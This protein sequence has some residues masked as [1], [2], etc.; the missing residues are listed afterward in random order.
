MTQPSVLESPS[1]LQ[2]LHD[3]HFVVAVRQAAA[4]LDRP[5]YNGRLTKAMDLVLGG[6]VTLH[7]DGTATVTSGAHT[8]DIRDT[9]SCEDSRRRSLYCKH[10]LAVQ[11]LKRTYERLGRP[12]NGVRNNQIDTPQ[13]AAWQCAQAPASCTLKWQL[14]GIELLLTLRDTTDDALFTR[15]KRVLPRITEKVD[16]QRHTL[17]ADGQRG[18]GRGTGDTAHGETPY[19]HTHG[20]PLTQYT[21]GSKVWFSHRTENGAWCRGK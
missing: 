1:P 14:N 21:K 12:V 4:T 3:D 13:S 10:F 6:S 2:S 19:C 5:E 15:L 20:V 8:Y 11:L 7:E 9:C 16:A 18:P 17:Q